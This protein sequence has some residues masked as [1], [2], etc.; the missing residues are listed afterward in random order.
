MC[1]KIVAD[2][3]FARILTN[4]RPWGIV[5][6]TRSDADKRLLS[7]KLIRCNTNELDLGVIGLTSAD[8]RHNPH[9]ELVRAGTNLV[10][11]QRHDLWDKIGIG[12]V[13]RV[14]PIIRIFD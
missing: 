6:V 14:V 5:I 9:E 12:T 8:R 4:A 10:Y 7:W 13:C 1:C 11:G 2:G 3:R